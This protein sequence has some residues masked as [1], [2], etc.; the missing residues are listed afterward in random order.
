MDN[1]IADVYI[2][3]LPYLID[4]LFYSN[5]TKYVQKIQGKLHKFENY[6]TYIS[7]KYEKNA[8]FKVVLRPV[9]AYLDT[10]LFQISC[11]TH[12]L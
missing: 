3:R 4:N 11:I 8:I 9:R 6:P 2:I 12:K 1:K 5:T 10:H 7:K